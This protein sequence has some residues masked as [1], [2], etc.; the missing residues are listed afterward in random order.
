MFAIVG[1][2][3]HAVP[4]ARERV[5]IAPMSADSPF[6]A[7]LGDAIAGLPPLL[8][9]HFSAGPGA[10]RYEGVMHRV[11]RREGLF[12]PLVALVLRASARRDML[13]PE[14]ATDVPFRIEHVLTVGPD[15]RVSMTWSRVFRFP[16][17]TRRF[18]AVMRADAGRACVVDWLGNDGGL[19]VDL[20]PTVDKEVVRIES[21]RQWIR[22]E[23]LRIE[24]PEW[25]AGTVSVREWSQADGKLGIR[26]ETHN[27]IIGPISC[28]EGSFAPV[29]PTPD[30]PVVAPLITA[31]PDAPSV[32]VFLIL[33]VLLLPLLLAVLWRAL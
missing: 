30:D 4:N 29:E 26:V 20:H 19:E 14:I 5:S 31:R 6:V 8:R 16:H 13:F 28:Y 24:I 21:G 9:D 15:G 33:G 23:R 32:H 7:V 2:P 27:A 12:G 18:V 3:Y 17:V 10:V 1:G 22:F 11:W 25:A